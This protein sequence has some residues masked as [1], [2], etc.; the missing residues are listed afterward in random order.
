MMPPASAGGPSLLVKNPNAVEHG[1]IH[2]FDIGDYLTREQKLEKI[3]ALGSINILKDA[4]IFENIE[5]DDHF[6]WLNKRDKS[7]ENYLLIGSKKS[8]DKKILFNDYT[9]GIKTQRDA[10]CYNFSR[11]KL[12]YNVSIT[13][14]Y[15]NSQLSKYK[16]KQIEFSTAIIDNDNEISWTRA[17]RRDFEKGLDIKQS[18]GECI[19]SIYRPFTKQNLYYSRRLNEEVGKKGKFFP[20][21]NIRNLAIAITGVGS[22]SCSALMCDCVSDLQLVFNGQNYPLRLFEQVNDNGDDLFASSSASESYKETD[23]ITTYG[24]K[25]FQTAYSKMNITKE[26]VFYYVYGLLHSNDYRTRYADNLSK[27]LP[28]IPAVKQEVDF[29]AFS[30]AGR[31]LGD[32]HVN[33]ETV[34]PYPV[35]I[36]EGDLRLAQISDPKSYFRVEQMRFA[37]K[38]PNLDKTT[39]IYNN[40]ITMTDI[41]LAAYD[42][43]VNGKS[44][45]DWV[46]ERQR[47]KKDTKSGIVNDANDYANETMNDPK[48]PF[49]LFQRVITVSLETMQI[50]NSCKRCEAPMV[51][52]QSLM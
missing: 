44:A 32:L 2:Y 50:V 3:R 6:D 47:V 49:E 4:G 17:L 25:H 43:V 35:T 37:G 5:A 39:V 40:N 15:Y 38:R 8:E 45:L 28:R 22:K 26:D 10:W 24:L 1:L 16:T 30:K 9:N 29:W 33:Y 41:P 52:E 46:M 11:V 34:K 23:G 13:R 19:V 14:D 7:F 51:S 31:A 21:C 18:E 12:K 48:Y 27:Q 20:N 42:Y 36:A